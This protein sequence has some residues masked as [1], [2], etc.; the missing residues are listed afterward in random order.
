MGKI[1][2]LLAVVGLFTGLGA[3][4]VMKPEPKP[5]EVSLEGEASDKPADPT[6]DTDPSEDFEYARLNNQFVIPVVKEGRVVSLVV[7]SA[8]L[9]VDIGSTS[10]V[11]EKEPKIRDIFLQTLF[12]HAN[13]G[14]FDGPFTESGKLSVLRRNLRDASRKVLGEVV[15]DVLILDLVRQDT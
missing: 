11:F 3:G 15:N 14:G 6:K 2:P 5:D 8:T 1:I 10:S 4:Y 12:D 9:E 7:F 13:A